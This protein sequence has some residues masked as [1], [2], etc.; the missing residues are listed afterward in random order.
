MSSSSS[1]NPTLDTYGESVRLFTL[2]FQ[3]GQV[4]QMNVAQVAVAVRDCRGADSADRVADRA[5]G[6]CAVGAAR[7]QSGTDPARQVDLRV[8]AAQRSFRPSVGPADAPS[9]SLASG[10]NADRRQRAD[11][12]RQGAVLPDDIAH[13]R[14]RRLELRVVE[15]VHRTGAR[16]ELCGSGDRPDLHVRRRQRPGRAGRRRRRRRRST[17]TSSRSRMR[18][19][20]SRTRWSPRKSCR[21]SRPR[22]RGWSPR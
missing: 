20:M 11:R 8:D 3:Y 1:P 5:D 12:R 19:P 7:P 21:S 6:E 10:G 4:S 22:R 9:G 18:S 13:R 14:S 16:V 2:Q 17:A 15:T